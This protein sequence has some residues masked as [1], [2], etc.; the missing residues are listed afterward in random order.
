MEC[1]KI[2]APCRWA[3]LGTYPAYVYGQTTYKTI[4]LEHGTLCNAMYLSSK[5][6]ETV[7]FTRHRTSTITTH[8]TTNRPASPNILLIATRTVTII[9]MVIKPVSQ[10][11]RSTIISRISVITVRSLSAKR[12]EVRSGS[13]LRM[14]IRKVSWIVVAEMVVALAGSPRFHRNIL[15]QPTGTWAHFGTNCGKELSKRNLVEY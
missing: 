3:F 13:S 5:R 6:R 14:R 7:N 12:E 8:S 9:L 11:I 4:I 2:I 15:C 1:L 10:E